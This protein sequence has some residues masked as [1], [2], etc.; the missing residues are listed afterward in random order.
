MLSSLHTSLPSL[1]SVSRCLLGRGY[2]TKL[3]L[4]DTLTQNVRRIGKTI[5][6]NDTPTTML[7]SDVNRLN[8]NLNFLRE[9]VQRNFIL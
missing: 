1:D 3:S 2:L 7:K 6:K 4:A 8:K 9:I 5:L